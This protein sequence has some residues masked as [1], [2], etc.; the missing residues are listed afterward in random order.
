MVAP[1]QGA[2]GLYKSKEVGVYRMESIQAAK[3]HMNTRTFL[4]MAAVLAI[5]TSFNSQGAQ[6]TLSPELEARLIRF[7]KVKEAQA[8]A[9]IKEENKEGAPDMWEF[10][11]A[12]KE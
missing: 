12:G 4:V 3:G 5:G 10:F 9:L 11:K 7:F 8:Q 1:R 6:K 2:Q